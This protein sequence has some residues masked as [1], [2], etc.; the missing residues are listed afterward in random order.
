M[1]MGF[2][3]SIVCYAEAADLDIRKV[4]FIFVCVVG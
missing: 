4:S 2:R 1:G 3:C